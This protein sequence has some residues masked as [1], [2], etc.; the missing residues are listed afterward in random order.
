MYTHVQTQW[1]S[2]YSCF[3]CFFALLVAQCVRGH[4]QG[5]EPADVQ[6]AVPTAISLQ[7]SP[8]LHCQQQ[9]GLPRGE[10]GREEWVVYVG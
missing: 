7:V 8:S 10:G 9:G 6:C 2:Y 4:H 3:C 5:N 1:L